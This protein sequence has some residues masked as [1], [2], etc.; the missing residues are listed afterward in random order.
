MASFR[1][2]EGIVPLG[3][4]KAKA[5]SLLRELRKETAGPLVITQNGRPAAVVLSPEAFDQM[6]SR[7]EEIEAVA[8]GLAD[9]V[10]GRVVAHEKVARWLRTWGTG[11]ER[12]PPG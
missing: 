8:A 11:R 1:V 5:S 3:E 10:A 4:F 12:E 2:A 6:R 7:Q 9:A